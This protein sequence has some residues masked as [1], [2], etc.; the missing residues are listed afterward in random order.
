MVRSSRFWVA[1]GSAVLAGACSSK[2]SVNNQADQYDAGSNDSGTGGGSNGDDAGGLVVGNDTAGTS[3]GGV[4]E[5]LTIKA[6]SSMVAVDPGQAM[7]KVVV[8]AFLGKVP[9]KVAWS[10][11]RG[12]LGSVG[13]GTGSETTF[14]P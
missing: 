4:N 9:V 5:T 10:V 3:N 6:E 12:D 7:P 14:T 8:R 11:D 1:L 13:P 2:P